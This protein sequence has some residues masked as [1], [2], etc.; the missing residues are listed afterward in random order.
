[1]SERDDKAAYG[2]DSGKPRV[3]TP[4]A[5]FT[6][7]DGHH[8]NG[9]TLQ[10]YT[11]E[12]MWAADAMGI[13]YGK[14]SAVAAKQ[15]T[16]TGTYPGMEGD[17]GIVIWLCSL[18]EDEEVRAARRDPEGAETEAVLFAQ[19]HKIVSRKQSSYWD[20]YNIFQKIMNEIH[21]AYGEPAKEGEQKKT[22][23]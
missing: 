7:S 15:Y 21:V 20:A 11:P 9:L 14:L 23:T 16:R 12:R 8:L 18:T 3:L 17:V 6:Q 22:T 13:R 1:M 10:P 5:A 19:E 4:D 2:S